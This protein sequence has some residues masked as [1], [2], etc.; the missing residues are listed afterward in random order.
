[1][2]SASPKPASPNAAAVTVENPLMDAPPLSAAAEEAKEEAEV[3][4]SVLS[5]QPIGEA[6]TKSASI[7]GG[8]DSDSGGR[9]ARKGGR[10]PHQN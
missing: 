5:L 3:E 6:P 7:R 8:G 1:M 2:S 4:R 9:G 10:D